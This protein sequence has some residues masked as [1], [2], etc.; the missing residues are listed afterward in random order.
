MK[1]D[2]RKRLIICRQSFDE[3]R[4]RVHGFLWHQS[5][6]HSLENQSPFRRIST[7]MRSTEKYDTER[8]DCD[9]TN[10]VITLSL[11][12]VGNL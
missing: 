12:I 8:R 3:N 6:Y 10:L 5:R 7:R 11:I 2:V 9:G 1:I 4:F